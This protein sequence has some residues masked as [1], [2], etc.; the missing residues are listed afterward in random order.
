MKN[1][2]LIASALAMLGLTACEKGLVEARLLSNDAS[3][4]GMKYLYSKR[5]GKNSFVLVFFPLLR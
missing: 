1:L 5:K 2:S 3:L 4:A